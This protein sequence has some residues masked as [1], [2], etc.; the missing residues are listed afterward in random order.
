[1]YRE[2]IPAWICNIKNHFETCMDLCHVCS[3]MQIE[4]SRSHSNRHKSLSTHSRSVEVSGISFLDA[5]HGGPFRVYW[6]KMH[7][8]AAEMYDTYDAAILQHLRQNLNK[9]FSSACISPFISFMTLNNLF[10]VLIQK[11]R[12][13]VNTL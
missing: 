8:S 3:I 11:A 4:V 2:F 6:Y 9:L 7:D 13:E 10:L 12:N 5:K 1:M